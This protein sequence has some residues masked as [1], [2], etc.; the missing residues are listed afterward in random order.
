MFN[1]PASLIV[2]P[3]EIASPDA[4]ARLANALRQ[5]NAHEHVAFQREALAV[6]EGDRITVDGKTWRVGLMSIV[7]DRESGRLTKVKAF[8]WNGG[9]SDGRW[10]D[11]LV[12]D[13]ARV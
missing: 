5:V 10:V 11:L 4:I 13:W 2:S 7:H 3:A 8:I 1:T 9:L 12:V 6:R